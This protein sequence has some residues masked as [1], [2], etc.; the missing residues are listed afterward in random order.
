VANIAGIRIV[1]RGLHGGVVATSIGGDQVLRD[2]DSRRRGGLGNAA[3][4]LGLNRQGARLHS[5]AYTL[6]M[7]DE[8]PSVGVHRV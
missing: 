8:L 2:S 5:G 4:W 6:D 3:I 7:F 1:D